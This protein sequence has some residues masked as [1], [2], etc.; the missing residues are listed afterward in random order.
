MAYAYENNHVATE[1]NVFFLF[2]RQVWFLRKCR[3]FINKEKKMVTLIPLHIVARVVRFWICSPALLAVFTNPAWAFVGT[4]DGCYDR[5]GGTSGQKLF[6]NNGDF[7]G[8]KTV[9]TPFLFC[10]FECYVLCTG[11]L[12]LS[13]FSKSVFALDGYYSTHSIYGIQLLLSRPGAQENKGCVPTVL[14]LIVV[15][16]D[17]IFG[18]RDST[19]N[20]AVSVI[21]FSRC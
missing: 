6:L 5:G 11:H 19:Y 15:C 14:L 1:S 10:F 4:A 9:E 8:P 12:A 2:F 17:K 7:Y 20:R 3:D 21:C 16:I 18:G 13:F